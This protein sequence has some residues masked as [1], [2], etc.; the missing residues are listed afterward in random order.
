MTYVLFFL[1]RYCSTSPCTKTSNFLYTLILPLMPTALLIRSPARMVFYREN[2]TSL[3]ST[4]TRR[5]YVD[6]IV[7][8]HRWYHTWLYQFYLVVSMFLMDRKYYGYDF[9]DTL[10]YYI[11]TQWVSLLFCYN[12]L[13]YCESAYVFYWYAFFSPYCSIPYFT[14]VLIV[15]MIAVNLFFFSTSIRSN[16]SPSVM[17]CKNTLQFSYW[18]TINI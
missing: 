5:W 12:N 4:S 1:T 6:S 15:I 9:N 11:L 2:T 17:K 14:Q 13:Y 8:S 7:Y 18:K 10:I 3:S 16:C